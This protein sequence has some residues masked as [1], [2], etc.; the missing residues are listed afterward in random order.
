M[1]DFLYNLTWPEARAVAQAGGL[2]RRYGWTDRWL[3]RTRGNLYWIEPLSGAAMHVVR[4]TDFTRTEFLAGDWTT[5]APDQHHCIL[6]DP[7]PEEPPP[8][9]P[10]PEPEPAGEPVSMQVSHASSNGASKSGTIKNPLKVAAKVVVNGTAATR[11]LIDGVRA[12]YR[13]GGHDYDTVDHRF[14]LPA[15]ASLSWRF[16]GQPGGWCGGTVTFHFEA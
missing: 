12:S 6:P 14:I 9:P 1:A 7:D 5:L 4:N 16:V 10:P 2:V 11:F 3:K 8:P 13:Q 15:D